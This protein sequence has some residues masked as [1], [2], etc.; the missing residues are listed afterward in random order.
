MINMD[1]RIIDLVLDAKSSPDVEQIIAKLDDKIKWKPLGNDPQNFP[2]L[3]M[4]SDPYGGITERITNA[5]D[6][7][8]ELEAEK[9][10]ELKTANHPRKAIEKIYNFEGGYLRDAEQELIGT[11]SSNIKVKFLDSESRGQ[12]TIEV[13]D[14]GIG[15]HPMD[16]PDTLV[17]INS[18]YKFRKFYLIGA[19]GQGGQ[20]SF[21]YCPYGIIISRKHPDLLKNGQNDVIGWTIVRYRDPSTEVELY[22]FGLWEYCIDSNTGKIPEVKPTD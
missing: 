8:I 4:G 22:K 21:A 1:R 9:N 19:F 5:M 13:L 12:P 14:K 17:N 18:D 11:L 6:A 3:S 10:P 2:R 15:Q 16:F 20:T 7:M